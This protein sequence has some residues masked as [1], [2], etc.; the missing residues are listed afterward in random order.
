MNALMRQLR[1]DKVPLLKSLTV[2]PLSLNPEVDQALLTMTDGRLNCF[3]HEVVPDYLR[4]KPVPEVESKHVAVEMRAS[5]ANLDAI[6]VNNNIK[7]Y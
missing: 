6:N 1:S 4:T 2:L 7:L 3:N 5:Q